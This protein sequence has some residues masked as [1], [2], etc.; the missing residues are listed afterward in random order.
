EYTSFSQL[1]A[2][3]QDVTGGAIFAQNNAFSARD[4]DIS[5]LDLTTNRNCKGGALNS[6]R[7]GSFEGLRFTNISCRSG[8]ELEGGALHLSVSADLQLRDCVFANVEGQFASSG[9]GGAL[10]LE[11]LLAERTIDI[12]RC[13]FV[14]NR[15]APIDDDAAGSAFGGAVSAESISILRNVTFSGNVAEAG[16]GVAAGTDGGSAFGG[17]LYL[18]ETGQSSAIAH[19]TMTGNRAV[20]GVGADGFEE[21]T[22]AGALFV[23]LGHSAAIVGSILSGNFVTDADGETSERDCE[24]AGTLTSLGYNLAVHPDASC[25]FSAFGDLTGLDPDLYPVGDY[26][27]AVPFLDGSCVPTAAI[28]QTSWAVDWGSCAEA[29]TP[30]DA[31]GFERRQDIAGVSNLSDACDVGAFEALDSDGDGVTDVPDLCPQDADPSQADGDGDQV[32]DACD[33]CAGD[34]AS[35]DGD[36]D[37]VCDDSDVCAGFDDGA[38]ADSDTVPDGCDLCL[39]DDTSGDGDA[40]LVCDDLDLCAGFDDALDADGDTVPD[41]CDVCAGGDDRVDVDGEGTPDACQAVASVSIDDVS[42]AEGDAGVTDFV[43]TVTLAGSPPGTFSVAYATQDG[44]AT[45]ASG[46]YVV[47]SGLLA[48]AG[49]DGETQTITVSVPGD[50]DIEG[51]EEFSVEIGVSSLFVEVTD[52]VGLGSIEG[53][54]AALMISDVAALEGDTGTVDFVFA[55]E[56]AGDVPGGFT[57]ALET[58]DGTATSSSGDYAAAAALLTFNGFDGEVQTFTVPAA[59]DAV[60]EGDETFSVVLGTPSVPDVSAL[61]TVG[62][63]TIQDDDSASISIGDVSAAEGDA[64]TTDFIFTAT[65]TGAVEGGL[66]VTAAT[67]DGTATVASGDYIAATDTL[68]FAGA[69]GETETLTVSVTGDRI[70]E[71][72]ETFSVLLGAPSNAL[73]TVADGTGVGT[74]QGGDDS[75]SLAI[76]DVSAVEGDSGTTDFIFLVTLSGGVEQAFTVDFATQDDTATAATGDYGGVMGTLTFAGVDG[77]TQGAV[78]SVAGDTE[79][80]TDEAFLVVLGVPSNV[81]VGVTDGTGVGVI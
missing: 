21:G 55:V 51:D 10:F 77:E 25:D 12:Q 76:S 26:G 23:E 30:D 41:G 49:N 53:D 42:M 75:A 47:A 33:L 19:V 63:G 20:A 61:G 48:F 22:A 44:T 3:S 45:A 34:D 11:S 8:L 58:Q 32:G 62:T 57:V 73:V 31:R 29:F 65:L 39:G 66:T 17:A 72:D 52:G 24:S 59:G 6:N 79:I 16:D 81:E 37:F 64:G 2:N 28:D 5:E 43:F 38:D 15:L 60:L 1:T 68:S 18:G 69:D 13:A 67:Q 70:V 14:D 46:D 80:E 78:V 27:C 7:G 50:T 40:D 36:G 74:I 35:G 56:L 71:G 9:R 4:I 54:D